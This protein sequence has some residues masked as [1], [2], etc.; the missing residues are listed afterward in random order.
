MTIFPWHETQWALFQKRKAAHQ[1]PHALLFSGVE[2]IGKRQF[3]DQLIQS[4][5]CENPNEQ[6]IACSVCKHCRLIQAT[7][8]PDL[9]IVE[10]EEKGKAIKIDQIRELTHFVNQTPQLGAYKFILITKAEQMNESAANAFLKTLEEPAGQSIII[11]I[12]NRLMSLLATIRSRCQIVSFPIPETKMALTWLA[13]QNIQQQN[14]ELL[15]CLAQG[16]PLRV[17]EFIEQ[18]ELS[19]RNSLF[20]QFAG[21]TKENSDF[22]AIADKW[23][24]LNLNQI[25][26][27]L[28]SWTSD[29]IKLKE[30]SG[31][32]HIVHQD[33]VAS[34]KQISEPYH[35]KNLFAFWEALKK[36]YQMIHE[37]L[38][39]NSQ[40]LIENLLIQWKK[41]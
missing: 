8:H 14:L 39:P 13:Q 40:L 32:A 24:K 33:M 36:A 26:M 37:Q 15:L 25:L 30:G 34:L 6:G 29:M 41:L 23:A 2:G 38:N 28:M 19:F 16:A 1:L 20:E 31:L 22:I 11:L 35:V 4:V 3:A 18:D 21:L 7:S 10:P 5:L 17:L 12:T 27:Y 9:K